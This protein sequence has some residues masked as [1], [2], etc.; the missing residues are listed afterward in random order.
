MKHVTLIEKIPNEYSTERSWSWKIY[1][2]NFL[3]VF[4]SSYLFFNITYYF[5]FKGNTNTDID[6]K[7][8]WLVWG[9]CNLFILFLAAAL[10]SPSGFIEVQEPKNYK[11]VIEINME[12]VNFKELCDT[13]QALSR[14]EETNI[15]HGIPWPEKK[16][17]KNESN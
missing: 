11:D 13:Y 9:I 2:Q 16:E 4:L 14:V 3:I 8:I 10:A 5:L 1:F 7:I 6:N 17:N 12:E 15:W